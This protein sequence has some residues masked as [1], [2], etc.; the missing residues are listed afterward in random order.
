[1]DG[2]LAGWLVMM[3]A[4]AYNISH[5]DRDKHS[6][7]VMCHISYVIK[8][9]SIVRVN[10]FLFLSSF[11]NLCIHTEIICAVVTLDMSSEYIMYDVQMLCIAK[12]IS[13]SEKERRQIGKAS[14]NE[15]VCAW[16]GRWINRTDDRM[17]G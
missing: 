6:I 9:E 8:L 10:A 15:S 13:V 3:W 16:R 5:R 17:K 11:T 14:E 12:N 2:W 1:M 4:T 7:P